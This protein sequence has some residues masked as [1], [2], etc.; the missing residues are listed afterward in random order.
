MPQQ[1][2]PAARA[3]TV[4]AQMAPHPEAPGA[5][6]KTTALP[7]LPEGDARHSRD[8][9]GREAERRLGAA[10]GA[11]ARSALGDYLSRQQVAAP[12]ARRV[13][14][15]VHVNVDLR[16]L[17]KKYRGRRKATRVE[18]YLSD[19][20]ALRADL[21]AMGMLGADAEDW[22]EA[23][24][25]LEEE[26]S[27]CSSGE[28]SHSGEDLEAS[29][30]G[31]LSPPP[32]PASPGLFRKQLSSTVLS[33]PASS[34]GTD[35]CHGDR[36][37]LPPASEYGDEAFD[38]GGSEG[39]CGGGEGV[40]EP[41]SEAGDSEGPCYD[42]DASQP[43]SEAGDFDGEAVGGV[44]SEAAGEGGGEG[45]GEGEGQGEA[46]L[47]HAAKSF[48]KEQLLLLSQA[49]AAPAPQLALP[50]S[51][52]GYKY[53]SSSS[54]HVPVP[55]AKAAFV[56]Y[57]KLQELGVCLASDTDSGVTS[58]EDPRLAQ[59][60][61]TDTSGQDTEGSSAAPKL[62][63]KRARRGKGSTVRCQRRRNN[64]RRKE[65]ASDTAKAA[66]HEE[67]RTSRLLCRSLRSG[68]I[69]ALPSFD[70]ARD[71]QIAATG[72]Q[73]RAPPATKR[74]V[75]R[76][77]YKSGKIHE[78]L[79]EF[80]RLPYIG[81][82]KEKISLWLLDQ[83][84]RVFLYRGFELAWTGKEKEDFY[85]AIEDLLRTTL[86][87]ASVRKKCQTGIRGPHFPSIMGHYRQSAK[88]PSLTGWHKRHAAEV[89]R[90][91]ENPL[92]QRLD[93]HTTSLIKMVFPGVQERFE[94]CAAWH[95]EAYGI[96][97]LF[98]SFFNLCV[99][100]IFPGSSRVH[101]LPHADSKNPVSI[102]ALMAYVLP[103]AKFNHKT[104]SWLVIWEAG[105][106]IELP[107][108]VIL[109]YPSSL[110][111]HFNNAD[112][113]FVVTTDG[114]PPREDRSNCEPLDADG[115]G[116]I[117]WFSMATMYQS[118]ETGF[119]TLKQAKAAGL[120]TA[121]DLPHTLKEAFTNLATFAPFLP[122]L[123]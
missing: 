77:R 19:L 100:G 97:P 90:F 103:N 64:L 98:G 5:T 92:V 96:K 108:W 86:R 118:A 47:T 69:V 76:E 35:N 13:D 106:V 41:A 89:N 94:R 120:S 33:S 104:R 39:G 8:L 58:A 11:R 68:Q 43:A 88:V 61:A 57:K 34:A 10:V 107:P 110:F 46:L 25:A 27:E 55:K 4:Q 45:E 111:Y 72:W 71:G 87:S 12:P 75:I 15:T 44:R 59:A 26:D 63:K 54:R 52:S 73:G 30:F 74:Q 22:L 83:R 38:A 49:H 48:R 95:Q 24:W 121:A 2:Q 79:T 81:P 16:E 82:S 85:Y 105:V 117:V 102:C 56:N 109:L 42:A 115:R 66:V 9:W 32:T 80:L 84:E 3:R 37:T 20:Q 119:A 40:S 122:N 91:L 53:G 114:Q 51:S 14:L 70:I 50:Q 7:L 93:R 62:G 28:V 17:L 123:N 6:P 21:V 99:N 65:Y 116:S 1:P 36:A 18:G 67:K 31:S 29:D 78:D 60:F 112:I 113:K 101:C 23:V